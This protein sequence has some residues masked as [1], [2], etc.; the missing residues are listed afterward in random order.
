[1][2]RV[3]VFLPSLR[4]GGAERVMLNL[5]IGMATRGL[6][7][8]LVLVD[9]RDDWRSK[10]PR[11][12]RVVDLKVA[13]VLWAIPGLVRYLRSEKPV[14]LLSALDHANTAAFLAQ[15]ISRIEVRTVGTIHNT[16]S[17]SLD[18]TRRFIEKISPIWIRL[19]YPL[20]DGLV[21]VSEGVAEDFSSST[22]LS[23]E[24]ISVVYNPVITPDLFA[25][26]D[27]PTDH[28]W[29]GSDGVP[30]VLSVGRLARQKRYD[31][32]IKAFALLRSKCAA[33]LVI[34]GEGGERP[35]LEA[36][37][38]ELGLTHDVSLPGFVSNPYR[39][40]KKASVFVLSSEWEGL[41]T[42]LIEAIALGTPVVAT[43]CPSGPKE[44]LGTGSKWLV[45]VGDIEGLAERIE[46][47][48]RMPEVAQIDL[49]QY[50]VDSA[51][52]RY[53]KVLGLET[54]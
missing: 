8:D 31:I 4:G 15:R 53:L 42:V 2:G 16:F 14:A 29:F 3:A 41:P 11:E 13:R 35:A 32:L 54:G 28:P 21:A 17:K 37:V 34:L 40:M 6:Q 52:S 39:Y 50:S 20:A 48:V 25:E 38:S 19:S 47:Q 9:G 49:P 1:M 18:N 51:V 43:D 7:V 12:I 23:R 22:G 36:L 27:E 5:A 30:V 45:P 10:V 46:A 33:K 44:I 24:R 26:S